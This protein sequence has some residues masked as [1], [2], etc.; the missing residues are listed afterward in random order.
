[1]DIL[2]SGLLG[3]TMRCARCHSHKYDPIPQ[4][5]YYRVVDILKGGFDFYNW[6]M[7]QK[8]PLAKIATPIRYLPYITPGATPVQLMKEQE[9]RE[10]SN[11]E[12]DRRIAELQETLEQK[13]APIKKKLL[14]QRL[15]QLPTS[16]QEDL[17]KLLD[18]PAEKRDTIQKYLAEKF[19]PL[20]KIEPEELKA[21]DIEYR[22]DAYET[23]R[24]IKRIE[25]RKQPEPKI[26]A[27]WDPGEPSPTYIMRR[28]D[29]ALPGARV[30]AGVPAV[31]TDGKTPFLAQPPFPGSR[32][33][34]RRL[35]FAKW[36]IAPENPLTARVMVNRMWARHFGAGIVQSLGNFGRTG[37]PP[38][39][40]ELLDWLATEFV[41]R[42]WNIKAMHRLM[43]T[44]ST[45]R[46]GSTVTPTLAKADPDNV[47]LARMPLKRLQ[48][49]LLYDSLLIMS[50]RFDE[51]RYGPPE[52]VEVR[53][54]GL[55]TP[56]STE[57]GWRRAIYVAE[58]RTEVPTLLESFDL[59]PMGPNCLERNT[60]TVAIQALHLMNNSMVEK[61][62][63]LFAERVR[64][65]AGDDP[66]KQIERAYWIALGRAPAED[67]RT[68]SVQALRRFMAQEKPQTG[69]AVNEKALASFC[70]ALVNSAAFLYID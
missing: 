17:R 27:L 56:I 43:M 67:E 65:E 48:A 33:T 22:R 4:R 60:S 31:L 7:P 19:A 41:R 38:T 12:L 42:G 23:G 44:S 62:A 11:A 24:Q 10:I 6:M 8:D 26:R 64:K 51:T 9:E 66:E 28:G 37:T 20:L 54:D 68:A 34:G 2:G 5:D 39:N 40:P 15:A 36:L 18:T 45:Y 30:S 53:D 3:L 63:E 70:H 25:F 32:S 29:P 14:D 46:Q 58:R 1:M 35:A 57:T 47:F 61:L 52:P 69:V 59:P 50:G 13:S 21:A 16:L 49:E 55:V